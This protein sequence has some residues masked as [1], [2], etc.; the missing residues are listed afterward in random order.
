MKTLEKEHYALIVLFILHGVGVYGL[1]SAYVEW[2]KLLTPLNLIIS[3]GLVIAFHK[4][5]NTAFWL[6]VAGIYLTGFLVEWAG[7]ATGILFGEYAYGAT[8]GFKLFDI[9]LMI[10]VNWLMLVLAT[11]SAVN[12]VPLPWFVKGP[13]AAVLM[14]FLDFLIEPVAMKHDMW[15]WQDGIIPTQNYVMWLVVS[16]VMC[17]VYF[18]VKFNKV[19]KVGAGLYLLLFGFFTLLNFTL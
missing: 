1:N 19:N 10:G 13:L 6:V 8:L 3:T 11:S 2:F 17:S 5:K 7:V 4:G 18:Y 16:L 12:K 14:V 15:M 9:P